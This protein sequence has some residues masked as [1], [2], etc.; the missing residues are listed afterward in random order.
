MVLSH[1]TGVR[2][3]VALPDLPRAWARPVLVALIA[4][5]C[6]G[7]G[8]ASAQPRE[9]AA[10]TPASLP[11]NVERIDSLGGITQYRLRSNGMKILLAPNRSAPVI[12]FL[13]VYHVGSRNE[14][15][16]HTGSAHLL[17]HMLFNKS[18]KNF[19]RANGHKT[20]QEI[21][22]EAGAD[23]SS[24]NMTT[25]YDRM[26]G[27]STLPSEKLS[28]AMRIEADRMGRAL[29]LDEERRPEMSVVI[30]E[31]EIGENNPYRALE[32]A[33]VGAAIV[34]HPYHWSTI[35][36][37]SDLE[38]VSTAKLREHYRNFFWPDNAEAIL[39]GDFEAVEALRLFDREFGKM[40]RSKSPIP[41]V[42]TVEPA[43][44]GE[45]RVIVS[46][47]GEVGIVEIA[48]LRPGSL[49]PDFIPLD[50]LSAILASGVNS[51]LYQAL[52]ETGLATDVDASNYTLRDP[53]PI[54]ARATVAAEVSHETVE[55]ALK[56]ALYTVGEKGVSEEELSRAKSQL[57]VSVIRGRDGTYE[58]ASALGE[59]VASAEWKWFARYIDAMKAVTPED[60]QRVARAYLLPDRATVGWFLPVRNETP[61][62]KPSSARPNRS[63]K[64]P[65]A[66]GAGDPGVSG[67]RSFGDRTMHRVLPNGITL[68]VVA[69]QAVP[70]V[71]IHGLV[72]AGR[73]E[74]PGGQSAVPQLTAAMLT[75]GT[76]NRSKRAIAARLDDVGANRSIT[77]DLSEAVVTGSALSRDLGLLLG[78]LADELRNPA[79]LEEELE[80]AKSELKAAL[81]RGYDN[82]GLRARE[83]LSR[84]VYPKGHPF[85]ARERDEMLASLD[86]VRVSDLRLFH[87][88]R[89][90]GSGTILSIVGDVDTTEVA[91]LVESLFGSLPKGERRRYEILRTEPNAP[92]RAVETL[93]GKANM[94]FVFGHA[95][96]LK[97]TDP[98]W[99]AAIVANAALGQSSLTSRIGKRV[100]DREGLS[101]TLNS[102]FLWSDYLDG[103]WM[104]DVNVAPKNLGKAMRSTREEIERYVKEGITDAEVET[105]KSYFAGNYRVRLG[106]NAG[107][108]FSLSYA[109]KYGYGP[110]YLDEFPDRVRAV[111]KDQVNDVIRARLHPEKLHLVV[112]G[113]L[114]AIPE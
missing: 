60:V 111:T 98:E 67:G 18:T 101:Y 114:E 102:R 12:T 43:Q 65:G 34:A 32:K 84:I 108:A 2:I 97:R 75:R 15:P 91:A 58:L 1:Q 28:L 30:N 23:F 85:R 44:E 47:P 46:R 13:V 89:Y 63:T 70:T 77:A 48:Y 6:I 57:E 51:R 55:T 104:V 87:Q 86:A 5:G 24:T 71:A 76:K 69:N 62:K 33:V 52:V 22:Y 17:E 16:G 100:R 96:G 112:A 95:S 88:D 105:Q 38:G 29:I 19:G 72:L 83:R 56:K 45:R 90:V 10:P 78:V 99:E 42:I 68:N 31:F 107:V 39:V 20:F 73:Q 41:E 79:F 103:V 3:P 53:Y 37:R 82:T 35:G 93:R 110:R 49:H 4:A 40:R 14:A 36:Y 50:L 80:K 59:A 81:L 109:Q 27:Y 94:N 25:W 113:D 11:A 8:G 61:K 26:T 106:T 92:E 66:G 9:G 7:A 74:T 64:R 21:L 54:L